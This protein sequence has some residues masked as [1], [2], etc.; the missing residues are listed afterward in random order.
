MALVFQEATHSYIL[1]GVHIPS[2]TRI[3][4]HAGIVSYDMVRADVLERKSKL[5]TLVHQACHYYD[6][7]DLDWSSISEEVKPRVDAWASFRSDTGFVPR[8]IEVRYV[9]TVNGMTYGLTADREGFFKKDEAII[10]IKT[11]ADVADWVAIQTAGYALGVP[12][13]EG[14]VLSPLA[15]FYRRRRLAVQLLPNGKYM[16]RDFEDRNDATVFISGL[17]ITNWKIAHGSALRK[18]E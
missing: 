14:Q 1:D 4:D 7:N 12:D 11:S 16:K 10:D 18:M 2:V 17:H 5:G 15:L 3:I 8:R 13:F 6:E 9:A